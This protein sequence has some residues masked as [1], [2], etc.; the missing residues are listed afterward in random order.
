MTDYTTYKPG[1]RVRTPANVEGTVVAVHPGPV[2]GRMWREPQYSIDVPG[3][4]YAAA[5]YQS[6]LTLVRRS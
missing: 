1:D 3:T 4:R 6:E 2:R 5:Y